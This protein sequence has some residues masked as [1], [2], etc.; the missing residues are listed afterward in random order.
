MTENEGER[1][2]TETPMMEILLHLIFFCHA[3]CVLMF[4]LVQYRRIRQF[5]GQ[6]NQHTQLKEVNYTQKTQTYTN[7]ET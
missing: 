4:V 6:G 2:A 7:H 1:G 3:M 5:A